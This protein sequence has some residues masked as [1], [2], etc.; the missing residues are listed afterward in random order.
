MR[1]DVY[2]SGT[3]EGGATSRLA[4]ADAL[5]SRLAISAEQVLALLE[6]GQPV[7]VRSRMNPDLA[8]KL[9]D[10]FPKE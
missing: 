7:R 1:L 2:I 10:D 6:L 4:A 9:G 5:A 3:F 8:E